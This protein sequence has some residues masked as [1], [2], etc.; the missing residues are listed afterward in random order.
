MNI[1]DLHFAPHPAGMGGE[2]AVVTFGNGYTA[3]VVRGGPFYTSDGT[4]EIAV[5]RDGGLVFD[6]PV[7]DD[8]LGYLDEKSATKA[9]KDIAA[10]PEA[11]Q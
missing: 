2:R 9:L 7:T 10:L 4:Y 8:V 6:T 5:M 1:T 11:G 3:S